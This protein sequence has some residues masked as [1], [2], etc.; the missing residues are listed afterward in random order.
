MTQQASG[1]IWIEGGYQSRTGDEDIPAQSPDVL[2]TDVTHR[3]GYVAE[4]AVRDK[5]KF[6]LVTTYTYFC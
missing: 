1:V 3:P 4:R 2:S 5:V 6:R